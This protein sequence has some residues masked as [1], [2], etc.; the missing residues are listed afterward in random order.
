MAMSWY[1]TCEQA[2]RATAAEAAGLLEA[3]PDRGL[4]AAADVER[5]RQVHGLNQ[6]RFPEFGRPRANMQADNQGCYVCY[7][8]QT[9]A[10]QV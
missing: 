7:N 4:D 6:V 8:R 9:F 2:A 3:D 1:C 10:V 5:R